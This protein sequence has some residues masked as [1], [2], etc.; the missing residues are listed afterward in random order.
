MEQCSALIEQAKIFNNTLQWLVAI[1]GIAVF[2]WA[3]K[4]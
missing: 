4:D 2:I 3:F 1:L